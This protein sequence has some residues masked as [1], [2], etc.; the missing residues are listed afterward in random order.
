MHYVQEANSGQS[1]SSEIRKKIPTVSLF[2]I[3][4]SRKKVS[5]TSGMF[6]SPD[7]LKVKSTTQ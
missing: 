5:E 6:H 3:T 1:I 7:A 2:I 4:R